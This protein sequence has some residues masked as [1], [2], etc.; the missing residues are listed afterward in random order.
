M[1][2]TIQ[3]SNTTRFVEHST[4]ISSL[5]LLLVILAG[6]G[7]LFFPQQ[8]ANERVNVRP[9]ETVQLS[10]LTIERPLGRCELM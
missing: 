6:L 10:P 8:V 1:T 9:E 5:A 4:K 7:S 2:A 3:S